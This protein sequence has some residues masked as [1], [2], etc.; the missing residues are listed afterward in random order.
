MTMNRKAIIQNPTPNAAEILAVFEDNGGPR[1][2]I[3]TDAALAQRLAGTPT[4]IPNPDRAP[5]EAEVFAAAE[6]K[7]AN[8]AQA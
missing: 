4:M 3:V 5:L 8:E 6:K 7:V 1:N 2:V